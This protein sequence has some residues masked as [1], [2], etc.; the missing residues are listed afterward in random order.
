MLT[1][2]SIGPAG[3]ISGTQIYW[4][5]RSRSTDAIT[6]PSSI[7]CIWAAPAVAS[8]PVAMARDKALI[9]F[10]RSKNHPMR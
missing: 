10:D 7:G 1:T 4:P 8:R 9:R 5:G 3:A 2:T 6:V